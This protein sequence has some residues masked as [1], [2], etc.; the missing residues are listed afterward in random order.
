MLFLLLDDLEQAPEKVLRQLLDFLGVKS[1]G[2]QTSEAVIANPRGRN[3]VARQCYSSLQ[4][5]RN[6]PGMSVLKQ[7][8][9]AKIRS[10]IRDC[11]THQLP[12]SR[13]GRWIA[14]RHTAQMEPLTSDMRRELLDRLAEPTGQL[15]Q[16]LGRDLTAWR[17]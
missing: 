17:S 5:L 16:F 3:F 10:K 11:V 7:A 13:L 1:N 4:H 8:V 15:E 14:H 2:N 6:V 9:P 12:D